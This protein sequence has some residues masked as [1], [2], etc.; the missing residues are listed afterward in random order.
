M[1]TSHLTNN[2]VEKKWNGLPRFVGP[3]SHRLMGFQLPRLVEQSVPS[4]VAKSEVR[5]H[6]KVDVDTKGKSQANNGP[7]LI[8]DRRSQQHQLPLFGVGDQDDSDDSLRWQSYDEYYDDGDEEADDFRSDEQKY[9]DSESDQVI[10]E[11]FLTVEKAN[12]AKLADSKIIIDISMSTIIR[13]RNDIVDFR[14]IQIDGPKYHGYRWKTIVRLE[15]NE[16]G[17]FILPF[18]RRVID[19]GFLLWPRVPSGC[20]HCGCIDFEK[21]SDSYHIPKNLDDDDGSIAMS[22][23]STTSDDY[24]SNSD[25]DDNDI[26]SSRSYSPFDYD[27]FASYDYEC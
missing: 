2:V 26:V 14:P 10:H 17:E 6:I 1:A 19:I 7:I 20:M 13:E 15:L 27:P 18:S 5:V 24:I 22:A 8:V 4:Q 12:R 16:K 11:L 23:S 9:E 25:S 3:F 21:K